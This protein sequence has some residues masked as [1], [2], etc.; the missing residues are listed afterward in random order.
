MN[1][2][3]EFLAAGVLVMVVLVVAFNRLI[4]EPMF[5]LARERFA[6]RK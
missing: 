6:A 2:H 5:K 3:F 4:W 1:K